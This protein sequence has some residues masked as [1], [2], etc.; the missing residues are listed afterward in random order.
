MYFLDVEIE[1]F[2][3]Q[4]NYRENDGP[5]AEKVRPW[6]MWLSWRIV[7]VPVKRLREILQSFHFLKKSLDNFQLQEI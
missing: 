6:W 4:S 7:E 5:V 2:I 3:F 1:T